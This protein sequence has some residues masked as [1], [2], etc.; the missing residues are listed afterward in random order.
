VDAS[1]YASAAAYFDLLKTPAK[2]SAGGDLDRFHWSLTKEEYEQYT[3]GISVDY[4][5]SWSRVA[6]S[7]PRSYVVYDVEPQSPAGKAGIRRGDRLMKVD[8]IDFINGADVTGIN[9]GVFPQDAV[10]HTL[11]LQRGTSTL[12]FALQAGQ[13]ATTPVR[14]AKV[15]NDNGTK[16]AYLYFDSFIAKSEDAL[17]T[18]F[19]DFKTQGAKELIIDMRYNGGGLLFISSQLAYMIA[20][21]SASSG[22]TFNRQVF[23]DKRSSENYSYDFLPY[24]L[25]ASYYYDYTRPLPS[26][27]L[28]RVTLLVGQGTASASEAVINSLKGIDV[29]VDLIGS[30]TY[31]KPY[32][33][34]PQG[35]CGRYYYAVEFKGEN[36]K[37]FSAFDTGFAPSCSV[38]DDLNFQLGDVSEPRLAE[39]LQY[40]KSRQCTTAPVASIKAMG[41]P[42][43]LPDVVDP[44]RARHD[45]PRQGVSVSTRR[46]P[47]S[48]SLIAA[49]LLAACQSS[50]LPQGQAARLRTTND[51][52]Q[53]EITRALKE[54]T[55]ASQL[56]IDARQLTESSTLTLERVPSK[57]PNGVVMQGADRALPEKFQL[58]WANGQCM[59]VQLSTGKSRVLQQADCQVAP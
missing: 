37:G 5:I 58:R 11:E 55:G 1:Q 57:D 33:F 36:H 49:V 40:I 39:A 2:N 23:N 35:N 19:N 44:K 14:D 54:L 25:T 47:L 56:W 30:T 17:I 24:A 22:K 7:R 42:E 3:N 18:A 29:G 12:A 50:A 26:L 41:S 38:K 27:D 8:G 21:P 34:T 32:G 20:G 9:N 53:Q 16:V 13:Y 52:V 43:R 10:Q 48:L 15:I 59:L 31:G 51:A 4:G 45:D 6:N 28:K 46:K